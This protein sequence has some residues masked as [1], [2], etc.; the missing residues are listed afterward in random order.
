MPLGAILRPPKADAVTTGL[1]HPKMAQSLALLQ[2][3]P[4]T[5]RARHIPHSALCTRNCRGG[6]AANVAR[7]IPPELSCPNFTQ[8][9]ANSPCVVRDCYLRSGQ[10][11]V[12]LLFPLETEP[13]R[14]AGPL[15]NL[16][17]LLQRD[18]AFAEKDVASF[19][20][21]HHRVL[22]VHVAHPVAD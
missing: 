5:H 13:A 1:R 15:E 21:F 9:C 11:R 20:L 3:L 22:Q 16:K 18:V 8:H 12:P 7:S 4:I 10:F 17:R 14:V 6:G 19:A 2:A